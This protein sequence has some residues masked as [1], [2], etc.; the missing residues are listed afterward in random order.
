MRILIIGAGGMLGTD[1]VKYWTDDEVIAAT[2]R[3]TNIV[4]IEQVRRLVL[5]T[6]PLWIIL[7]AAYTDVDASERN[8]EQ[9]FAVNSTGTENV[10]RVATEAGSRLFYISTDY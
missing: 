2:S 8:A 5:M 6:R 10:A 4:D 7:T 9:A 1:L 3:D